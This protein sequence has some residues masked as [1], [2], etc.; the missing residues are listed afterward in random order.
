MKQQPELYKMPRVP[1]FMGAYN[2]RASAAGMFFLCVVSLT[3]TQYIAARFRYQ[4]ALGEP[5]VK[6]RR[7]AIYQPF[8]WVVRKMPVSDGLCLRAR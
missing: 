8:G 7:G 3:A 6:I 2:W 5:L 1:G 4:A